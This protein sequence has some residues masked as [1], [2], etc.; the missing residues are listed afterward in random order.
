[1]TGRNEN[2]RALVVI[3]DDE[4][5]ITTFLRLALEEHGVR[6]MTF[7]DAAAAMDA[8]LQCDPDLICLDLLMPRHTGLSLYAELV[9]DS[10]L[11]RCPVLI[12]SGLAVRKDLPEMLERA[13]G[14]PPPAGLIDKPIDIDGFLQHVD[15][16]LAR[17]GGEET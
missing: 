10:R 14:L 16:L 5:D 13:G 15:S 8:L 7:S 17:N 6:A 1:M 12:M 4:A 2:R 11:R 3:V 9:H